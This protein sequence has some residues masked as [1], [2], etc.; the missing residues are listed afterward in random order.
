MAP[1]FRI[2]DLAQ[3]IDP[4]LVDAFRGIAT[5]HASD[6][7]NRHTGMFGLHRYHKRGYL[8]GT[9]FTVRT[10]PG[11]NLMI[12][13]AIDL[14]QAGDVIVID[15]GGFPN[16]ALLGELMGRQAQKKGI[17]GFVVDGAI[18]DI[19]WFDDFPCYARSNT[20]RGPYKTGPGEINVPVTVGGQVVMPGDLVIGDEDGVLAISRADA[21]GILELARQKAA[22]EE[23]TRS[24]IEGEGQDRSWVAR[25]LKQAGLT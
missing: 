11:D 23:V 24:Q 4:A 18:R 5:S 9:A 12:H 13:H 16:Q 21:P 25:A 14:A 19:G 1:G 17:A 22:A 8:A 20:H 15:G 3:R 2:V 6:S 10:S 7:M